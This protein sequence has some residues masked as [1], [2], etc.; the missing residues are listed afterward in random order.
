MK[1]ALSITLA[2]LTSAT[3]F[4][5]PS[6]YSSSY[7]TK[8]ERAL[9]TLGNLPYL[10]AITQLRQWSAPDSEPTLAGLNAAYMTVKLQGNSNPTFS[11]VRTSFKVQAANASDLLT[12]CIVGAKEEVRGREIDCHQKITQIIESVRTHLKRASLDLSDPQTME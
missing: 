12:L 4:A 7:Q 6:T 5:R 9:R 8:W 10:E 1:L 2:L 11:D 3:A